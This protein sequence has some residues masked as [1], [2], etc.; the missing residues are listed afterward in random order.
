MICTNTTHST[1]PWTTSASCYGKGRKM[2]SLHRFRI[3]VVVVMNG[4]NAGY[5]IIWGRLAKP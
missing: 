3:L 4:R 1:A 5:T 2:E